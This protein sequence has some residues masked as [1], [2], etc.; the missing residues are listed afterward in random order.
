M[1]QIY[2]PWMY[3]GLSGIQSILLL[4]VT[5]FLAF[6]VKNCTGTN[7]YS[8]ATPTEEVPGLEITA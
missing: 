2:V 1:S 4:T 7:A 6:G 3:H 8:E 5:V